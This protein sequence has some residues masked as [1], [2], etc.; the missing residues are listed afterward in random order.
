MIISR[1][2]YINY[3][4]VIKKY[5]CD[6]TGIMK[7][8]L[9]IVLLVCQKLKMANA[10]FQQLVT[11]RNSTSKDHYGYSDEKFGLTKTHCQHY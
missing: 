2:R 4:S 6:L 9:E 7:M 11:L 1:S 8:N 5:Y 10:Q 3:F